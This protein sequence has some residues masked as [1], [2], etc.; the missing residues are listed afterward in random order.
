[1][2]RLTP[3]QVESWQGPPLILFVG[4][5]TGGSLVHQVFDRWAALLDRPWTLRGVDLPTDTPHTT[6]RRLVSAM[7]GNPA[8]HGA[9]ITAHKL[10]L[11]RACADQL[12]QRDW[13]VDLTHEVNALNTADG[14]AAGYARDALSLSR[15]VPSVPHVLCLGAGGAGTALLLALH[16]PDLAANPPARL[17][18]ADTSPHALDDLRAVAAR[19][20]F[21]A[22]G[23]SFVHVNGPEDCDALLAGMPGPALVINATGLGKDAPGSPVTDRAPFGPATVAWDFNYRGTLTFLRQAAA[24]GARTVDG[25]DYFVAGWAG[26]LTAL[27]GTSFTKDLL[28]DFGQAA[29]PFRP[30]EQL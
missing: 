26:A 16:H 24:H 18:F 17:V 27:A 3:D 29:A 19:A 2:N 23:V 10:R 6:Y 8:V 1:M 9:V 13:L 15:V 22:A 12:T 28:T 5:D 4:V 25:W 7:R 20:R 30:V 14:G 11:H 21:D